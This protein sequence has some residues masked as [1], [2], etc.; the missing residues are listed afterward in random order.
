MEEINENISEKVKWNAISA[1]LMI[2]IS[3]LFLFNKT[4]PHINNSFVKAHTK[5]A[6][7]IHFWFLITYIIFISNDLF[8]WIKIIWF[9]VNHIITDIIYIWL[10]ILLIIWI[11]KAKNWNY[12]NIWKNINISKTKNIVDIDWNW[13]ITEKEKVTILLSFIPFIGFLNYAKYRN[14]KIIQNWV[15]L[16]INITLLILL[17]SIFSYWNLATLF[18]LAYIVIITFIWIN[19]FTRD[20]II[21]INLPE[22]FSPSKLYIETKSLINYIWN[23]FNKDEFKNFKSIKKEITEYIEKVEIE[24]EDILK[25]KEVLKLPKFLIYIPIINLIFLFFR[26]TKYSFHIINWLIITLLVIITIWLSFI[27]YFNSNLYILLLFPVLFWMWYVNYKLAYKMPIIFDIYILL[28][29]TI[30]IFKFWS[31]KLKEKRSEENE[32]SL[33]VK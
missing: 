10:L 5:T 12:F 16:N 33:R 31:K 32:I 19:L 7:L 27:W 18:S 9:W 22:S 2:F 30:S 17:L 24:N 3:W 1:Y 20:E 26:N 8:A 15:R 29:K 21:N 4:N 14:N 25:N 11:Y 28:K 6:M 13:K 23:Y